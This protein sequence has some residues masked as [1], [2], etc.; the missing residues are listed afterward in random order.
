[1]QTKEMYKRVIL[2]SNYY[3]GVWYFTF[4]HIIFLTYK[5]KQLDFFFFLKLW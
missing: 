3:I 2:F 4:E 1:M 5:L